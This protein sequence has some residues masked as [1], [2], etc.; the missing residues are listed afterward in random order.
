MTPEASL[1]R[2]MPCT[3][4]KIVSQARPTSAKERAEAQKSYGARLCMKAAATRGTRPV[5]AKHAAGRMLPKAKGD[6]LD[7]DGSFGSLC[8]MFSKDNTSPSSANFDA[9]R[10]SS[11]TAWDTSK[12]SRYTCEELVQIA[13]R[14][15]EDLMKEWE[16][17]R[18]GKTGNL[19]TTQLP[20]PSLVGTLT[21]SLLGLNE[22]E[23]SE[24][25]YSYSYETPFPSEM[26]HRRSV[27]TPLSNRPQSAPDVSPMTRP[28]NDIDVKS[29][30]I[31]H[32]WRP[33][34]ATTKSDH[35]TRP[36]SPG[37]RSRPRSATSNRMKRHPEY[38][39]IS[40]R[41]MNRSRSPA[42]DKRL[43]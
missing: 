30:N 24:V 5:S 11:G 31:S 29:L 3:P 27:Y 33:Q 32:S 41:S 2:I 7:I 20:H 17:V 12:L 19:A 25:D 26:S 8:S 23:G 28:A 39:T 42:S 13:M 21:E 37:T 9:T 22:E 16:R 34:S 6:L 43:H 40:S 38:I 18:D 15:K 35:S 4:G 10:S 14:L 36:A 1:E